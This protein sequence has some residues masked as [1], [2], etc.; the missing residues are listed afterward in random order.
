MSVAF[1]I[2]VFG[3]L[4]AS[5]IALLVAF[6]ARRSIA[7]Y[8]FSAGLLVLGAE[9]M[10][11][12][13]A[14][15]SLLV[16]QTLFW[17]KCTFA[18]QSFIPVVWVAF[19]LVYAR[20]A[21]TEQLWKQRV[22]LLAGAFLPVVI[23]GVF[24]NHLVRE[25]VRTDAGWAIRLGS[26]GTAL[27]VILLVSFVIVLL[28]LERTFRAAVGTMRWRIKYMVIGL[29]VLFVV[30]AY[31]S[32]QALLFHG[33]DISWQTADDA[34]LGLS[35][36]ILLRSLFRA[37]NFE[38]TV[39]P[40]QAVITHSLTILVAG[41]YLFAVGILAKVVTWLGGDSSFALKAFV[42]LVCLILLA[43]VLLSDRVRLY[44]RQLVSRHFQ[45]P[46][47][48]Y[49]AVWE[50]VTQA[51]AHCV[52]QSGL[53]SAVSKLSSE[54][55]E[56]LSVSIWLVD[57]RR[58]NLVLEASTFLLEGGAATLRLEPGEAKELMTYL[59]AHPDPA[60]IEKSTEAWAAALRRIHPD[61]FHKGGNRVCVPINA[62][63]ELL[64]ILAMGDRVGGVPFGLQDMDLLKSL[65]GHVAGSLLNIKLSQELAQA[66]QLEA[67]QAMSAF[68]VHDLKNTASTLSLMLKNLPV[69]YNDP[70]FRED[71]LRGI[72]RTVEHVNDIISR[73]NALRQELAIVPVEC[74]LNELVLEALK[75]Q[76]G[77]AGVEFVKVLGS[78]PR[79][80]V[81]PVQFKKVLTNL[82]LNSLE[83]MPSGGQ[84]RIETHVDNGWAVL[85]VSDSGC[86]MSQEFMR[87]NLFRPFQTTK[88]RG[89]GIGMFHCKM[90]VEAHKGRIEVDSEEGR[91]TS[92]RVLLPM[93][94]A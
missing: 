22:M 91:G 36:L 24:G 53:C 68:F 26:G 64:G 74:D 11:G 18:A 2:G 44:T 42:V 30:R 8:L 80:R 84:V 94:R 17:V 9:S 60:D 61:Q 27:Q 10:S 31:T 3:A 50:K 43:T 16:D 4:I 13:L 85:A 37:G 59:G 72:S 47:H 41:L 14:G 34:A 45:R 19:S 1:F 70:A 51:T 39:Y 65:S 57:S 6:G 35:C 73:L 54:I 86:G 23:V 62:S 71:A 88:K 92:F 83:A 77:A 56:A 67:F 29:G 32:S 66:K 78:V 15:D 25:I 55:F 82:M 90:I 87:H 93:N 21:A 20:G 12:A 79:V 46:V 89:I 33:T 52:D 7:H 76:E 5:V 28:N 40:S 38:V 63:G 75:E 81:D 69:H 48:D 58:A 49:R